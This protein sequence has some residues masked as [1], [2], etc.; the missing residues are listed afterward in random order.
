[1]ERISFEAEDDKTRLE[2]ESTQVKGMYRS[3]TE[4]S[5]EQMALLRET[6][7]LAEQ[8]L[9]ESQAKHKAEVAELQKLLQE[10]QARQALTEHDTNMVDLQKTVHHTELLLSQERGTVAEANL[11]I[12]SL[13][14]QLRAAK[15]INSPDKRGSGQGGVSKW[16]KR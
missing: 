15:S 8:A 6:V 11:K 1:M 2:L 16:F 13:Q 7:R 14:Q 4:E 10:H 9:S 5:E 12:E 3:A